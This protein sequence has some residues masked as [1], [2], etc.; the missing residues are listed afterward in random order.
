MFDF[1]HQVYIDSRITSQLFRSVLDPLFADIDLKPLEG[2]LMAEL[3]RSEGKTINDLS[4]ATGIG[5]TNL[6]KLWRALEEKG[7]VERRQDEI[8]GRSF[9]LF[10]TQEGMDALSRLDALSDQTVNI[11]EKKF[12]AL[13]ERIL[14]G[15]R[16]ARELLGQSASIQENGGRCL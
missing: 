11:D 9:R 2:C 4:R 6:A 8:D 13:K 16:A 12:D 14:D 3:R 1:Y 15:H 10:L 5:S 7:Y